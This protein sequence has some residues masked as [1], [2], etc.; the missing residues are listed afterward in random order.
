MQTECF[1]FLVLH[2]LS[3]EVTTPR[4]DK[5]KAAQTEMSTTPLGSVKEQGHRQTSAPKI[6]ERQANARSHSFLEQTQDLKVGARAA[7]GKPEL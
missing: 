3:V 1:Q 4:P 2:G 6:G 5:S 7:V